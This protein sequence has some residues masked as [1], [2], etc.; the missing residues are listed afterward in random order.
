LPRN[1]SWER[2]RGVA[3]VL[4]LAMSFLAVPSSQAQSQAAL[5]SQFSVD[6]ELVVLP[7][8]VREQSGFKI[9][10]DRVLQSIRLFRH[11]DIPVIAGLLVNLSGSMH[12]KIAE[13]ITA[14]RASVWSSNPNEEDE[15]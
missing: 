8:T 6:V 11:E 13:A 15:K 9:Y 12:P 2:T 1:P 5:S 10:E 4:G 7:V 3:I 14:S